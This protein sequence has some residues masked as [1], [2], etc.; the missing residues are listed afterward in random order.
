MGL[1]VEVRVQG[2][3][4]SG[5][6]LMLFAESRI[7]GSGTNHNCGI[8]TVFGISRFQGSQVALLC[9][10]HVYTCNTYIY[11]YI[12]VIIIILLCKYTIF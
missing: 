6:G 10:L 7:E 1:S 11:I 12:F 5:F 9:P 2:S 8:S 4:A 3:G